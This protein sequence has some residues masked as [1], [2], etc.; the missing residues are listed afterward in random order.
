MKKATIYLICLSICFIMGMFLT[1]INLKQAYLQIDLSDP[2][3]NYIHTCIH[4]LKAVKISGSNGYPIDIKQKESNEIKFLKSRQEHIQK[5]ISNDTLYIKFTGANKTRQ[6]GDDSD[7]AAAI[8]LELQHLPPVY[9]KNTFHRISGFKQKEVHLYLNGQAEIA[10]YD[11][12]AN[13]MVVSSNNNSHIAFIKN[14]YMNT[15]DIRL[16]EYANAYFKQLQCTNF[17]PTLGDNVS[18]VF[19]KSSLEALLKIDQQRS[20]VSE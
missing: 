7:A 17:Y 1:N 12:N 15:L 10:L 8:I 9:V 4:P 3:K 5:K 19:S 20:R 13:Y 16:Q 2:Y 14:N 11:C 6:T 18:M